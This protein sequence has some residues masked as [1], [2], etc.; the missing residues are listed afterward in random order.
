MN[1][2]GIEIDI[3]IPIPI[4]IHIQI[5]IQIENLKADVI[6]SVYIL[7]FSYSSFTYI[8]SRKRKNC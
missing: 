4:P 3:S 1:G 7:R 5:Q 8:K 2:M 6:I